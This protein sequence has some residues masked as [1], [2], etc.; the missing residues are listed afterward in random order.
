M[1]IC[2]SVCERTRVLSLFFFLNSHSCKF[3]RAKVRNSRDLAYTQYVLYILYIYMQIHSIYI[4]HQ[5]I[6]PVLECY[7]NVSPFLL[8]SPFP[9]SLNRFLFS[10]QI[11]LLLSSSTATIGNELKGKQCVAPVL[12]R[13][14]LILSLSLFLSS[15]SF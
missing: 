10:H 1:W 6:Y 13:F 12:Y 8:F 11:L 14:F 2:F 15:R 4:Y 9:V 5:S 3:G 7:R